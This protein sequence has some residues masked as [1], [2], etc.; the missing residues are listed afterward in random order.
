MPSHRHAARRR[1]HAHQT[2]RVVP[3][4]LGLVP[5]FVAAPAARGQTAPP[6]Y[7]NFEGS[8]TNPIRLSPDGSRLFAVNTP[9][10]RLSVFDVSSTPTAPR[11]V[12]EIPVGIE[13]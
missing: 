5:A 4:L 10:A 3:L 12:G 6:P 2:R 1:N 9:D 7:T 8:Q 13:P 11:L